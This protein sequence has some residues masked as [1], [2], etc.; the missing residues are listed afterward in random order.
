V[1][2]TDVLFATANVVTVKLAEVCPPGTLTM[3]KVKKLLLSLASVRFSQFS[4][5]LLAHQETMG[6]NIQL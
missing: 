4:V 5:L 3:G 2:V 1:I 6:G